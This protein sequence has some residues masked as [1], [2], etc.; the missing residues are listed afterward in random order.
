[1]LYHSSRSCFSHF[2]LYSLIFSLFVYPLSVFFVFFLCFLPFL[3]LAVYYTRLR[4][5]Y[6]AYHDKIYHFTPNHFWPIVGV[7]PGLPTSLLAAQ[8][9][10]LPCASRD[11]LHSQT[12]VVLFCF[13]ASRGIPIPIRVG[14]LSY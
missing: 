10:P 6:I 7:L 2:T 4:P 3:L 12:K 11:T 8:P 9:P 5:F 14:L 13:L 1:M